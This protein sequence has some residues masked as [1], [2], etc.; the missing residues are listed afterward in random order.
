MYIGRYELISNQTYKTTLDMWYG[1]RDRKQWKV[2]GVVFYIEAV[3][4]QCPIVNSKFYKAV[5]S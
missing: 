5:L 2:K 3:F 4:G 1:M